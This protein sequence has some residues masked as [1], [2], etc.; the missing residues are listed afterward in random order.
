MLAC[1]YS[2][3]FKCGSGECIYNVYTCNGR[4]NCQD[5]SD[6]ICSSYSHLFVQAHR[7]YKH[8]VFV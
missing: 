7:I 3:Q 6:E 8:C 1:P 5:G 2:D 4:V